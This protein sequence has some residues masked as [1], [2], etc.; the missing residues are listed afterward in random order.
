[1][2]LCDRPLDEGD[3][4]RYLNRFELQGTPMTNRMIHLLMLS[5][6]ITFPVLAEAKTV[7]VFILSG[8]SNMEG[9]GN[10]VHLDTY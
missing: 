1:M 6:L 2:G 7:K 9:K 5:L 10:P 8:Q 4:G 3:T